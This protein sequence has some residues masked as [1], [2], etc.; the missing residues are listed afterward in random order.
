MTFG[1]LV[2]LLICV[3]LFVAYLILL[4]Q[5]VADLFR[6]PNVSGVTKALWVIGL[7]LAPLLVALAYLLLRGRGM[8]ERQAGPD[9]PSRA[10]TEEYIRSLATR[11][12]PADQI[13]SAK[14]LLDEHVITQSQYEHLKSEALS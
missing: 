13:S 7:V 12:S 14:A 5:I 11:S 2:G 1:Q 4:F 8:S 10:E 3:Y 6:D 9:R